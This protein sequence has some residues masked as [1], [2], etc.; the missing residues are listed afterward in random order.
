MDWSVAS[1]EFESARERLYLYINTIVFLV[2]NLSWDRISFSRC[3]QTVI[4]T[5]VY[6]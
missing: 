6:G 3:L 5:A 1:F 4:R 2:A